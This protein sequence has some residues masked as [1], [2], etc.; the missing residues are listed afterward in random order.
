MKNWTNKALATGGFLVCLGLSGC[1]VVDGDDDPDPVG[2]LT[3]RWTIDGLTDPLDCA[4]L[5]V[6]RLELR[7]YDRGT[8]EIGRASCRER[9]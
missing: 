3:V 2:T 4:D 7:L 5:G 1:L 6:D 9:V 8:L